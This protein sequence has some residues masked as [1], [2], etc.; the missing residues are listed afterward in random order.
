MENAEEIVAQLK[1]CAQSI[2]DLDYQMQEIRDKIDKP[3]G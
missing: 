3:K 2:E 1:A